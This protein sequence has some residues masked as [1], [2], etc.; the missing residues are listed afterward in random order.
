MPWRQERESVSVKPAA[1]GGEMH[2]L[3]WSERRNVSYATL[4][5]AGP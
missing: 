1:E 4:P 2:V 5:V 3:A